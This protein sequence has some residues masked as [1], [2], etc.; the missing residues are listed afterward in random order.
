MF[1]QLGAG[2][3]YRVTRPNTAWPE[4]VQ[5]LGAFYVPAGG[6]RYNTTH[7]PTVSCSE[8]PLVVLTEAAFYQALAWREAIAFSRINAVAYPFQSEH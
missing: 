8:D 5:G 6:N 7:Q 2:D 3:L 4:P 1:Y